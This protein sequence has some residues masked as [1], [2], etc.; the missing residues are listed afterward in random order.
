MS[1]SLFSFLI[2]T[3]ECSVGCLHSDWWQMFKF[4][5]LTCTGILSD[6]DVHKNW[7]GGWASVLYVTVKGLRYSQARRGTPWLSF[8][9]SVGMLQ[10]SSTWHLTRGRILTVDPAVGYFPPGRFTVYLISVNWWSQVL[11]LCESL[12]RLSSQVGCPFRTLAPVSDAYHGP[13]THC[14]AQQQ[15]MLC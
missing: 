7:D 13:P 11:S 3:G 12:Y 10:L 8:R 1:Q 14:L 2:V 6:V 5:K 15:W 4:Y 9:A